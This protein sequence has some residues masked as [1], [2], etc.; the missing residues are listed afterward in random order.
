MVGV[1]AGYSPARLIRGFS[2]LPP[3][4]STFKVDLT[5]SINISSVP[6]AVTGALV[7][8][9]LTQGVH[10][11]CKGILSIKSTSSLLGHGRVYFQ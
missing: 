10:P 6:F 9:L 11:Y 7:F 4:L 8:A 2:H 3:S 5:L 1:M